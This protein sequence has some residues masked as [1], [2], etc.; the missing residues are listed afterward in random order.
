MADKDSHEELSSSPPQPGLTKS[1]SRVLRIS[2]KKETAP[3]AMPLSSSPDSRGTS[4]SLDK[5]K[6]P[7]RGGVLKKNS[8]ATGLESSSPAK[9]GGKGIESIQKLVSKNKR[10]FVDKERGFN[11]DLSYI[12]TR[13]IAMGFPSEGK[14]AAY[15][16]PMSEV[17]RFLETFH[18]G[19]YKVY[20]LCSE[21][22]YDPA[23][24]HNNVARYPFDDHNA[25]PLKLIYECCRDI[26][27][28]MKDHPSNIACIHCK[29]G[30]GRT[31]VIIASW[32]QYNNEWPDADKA[33][34]F[35]A[36]A[37]THNQKGVTIP[38]QIRYV[39]YFGAALKR[40][41]GFNEQPPPKTVMLKEIV[42]RDFV[43]PGELK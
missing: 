42:L 10:R 7:W 38:S 30:K 4:G 18:K 17:Y 32:L 12:G 31:G 8:V 15:R 24:F 22:A 41:G 36:A 14:E 5:A 39:R 33:L 11:L 29:A 34:A 9:Q 27:A 25:P 23:V 16:N 40:K 28:W 13:I 43:S 3:V 20:N 35:Y 37:R 2:K 26:D 1:L 21:R 19:H 6:S